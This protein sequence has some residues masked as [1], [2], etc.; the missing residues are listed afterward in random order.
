[1]GIE[2]L[3]ATARL[4]DAD[5]VARFL[6]G[7][8]QPDA[9]RPLLQPGPPRRV[10]QYEAGARTAR[11][12]LNDGVRFVCFVVTDVSLEEARAIARQITTLAEW[13]TANFKRAVEIALKVTF[14]PAG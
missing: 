10:E 4:D 14:P 5:G 1:M 13:T 7:M 9:L 11:Y 6:D 12:L 8:P 2:V 3:R